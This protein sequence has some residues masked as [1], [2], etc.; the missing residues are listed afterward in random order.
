MKS[1]VINAVVGLLFASGLVSCMNTYDSYGRPVQSVDP[2]AAAVG[3]AA[4]GLV[5]YEIGRNN[6][7]RVYYT[8]HRP[9]YYRGR[10]VY[11]GPGHRR[12]YWG[13]GHR[14]VWL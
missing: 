11:W 5:G 7:D 3:V 12:Y 13:P 2:G 4:A 6:G 9:Y 14:R 10:D 1:I 8:G